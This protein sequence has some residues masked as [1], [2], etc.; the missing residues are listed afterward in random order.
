MGD[1]DVGEEYEVVLWSESEEEEPQQQQQQLQQQQQQ[2]QQL[3]QPPPSAPGP[4]SGAGC[5]SS[6]KSGVQR[7][8]GS[9]TSTG[10]SAGTGGG[11]AETHAQ[12]VQRLR[13]HMQESGTSQAQT[14][15]R[16]GW[17]QSRLS[18]WLHGVRLTKTAVAQNDVH[19]AQYLAR[20]G[21]QSGLEGS[22][23]VWQWCGLAQGTCD[24]GA[25]SALGSEW[26]K[27]KASSI[28]H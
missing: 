28:P 6:A 21:L 13:Q 4:S 9:S 7:A 26:R 3:Q 16:I 23:V 24:S 22:G 17:V 11:A 14:S 18:N 8:V 25:A 1:E 27:R 15:V 5:S 20:E 10:S 19:V 2:P 12:L